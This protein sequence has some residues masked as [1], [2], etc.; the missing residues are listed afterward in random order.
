MFLYMCRLAFRSIHIITN[1]HNAAEMGTNICIYDFSRTAVGWEVVEVEIQ[2]LYGK[3]YSL[4][5]GICEL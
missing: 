2:I 1:M 3:Q 5:D 4:C